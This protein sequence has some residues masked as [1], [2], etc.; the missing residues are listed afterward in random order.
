M[1]RSKKRRRTAGGAR[2][3]TVSQPEEATTVEQ[4]LV[5]AGNAR[6][7]SVQPEP[8]TDDSQQTSTMG[9]TI[10][11]PIASVNDNLGLHV[12][13]NVKQKIINGE[14]IELA[15]LLSNSMGVSENTHKISLIDGE[16][17]VKPKTQTPKILDIS[18]WT[19]AFIIYISIYTSVHSEQLHGLLKYMQIVRLGAQRCG[20]TDWLKYDEQYRLRKS[21]KPHEPWGIVD[22]ELYLIY[23]QPQKQALP[24]TQNQNSPKCFDFNY[25]GSCAR[26]HCTYSH[27]CMRCNRGH[28]SLNCFKTN[29]SNANSFRSK[30]NS[31]TQSNPKQNKQGGYRQGTQTGMD[32]GKNPNKNS[33]S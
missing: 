29:V 21:H 7:E 30:P 28:A 2:Q 17:V 3:P 31:Y 16:L 14:Y 33:S 10:P 9:M 22:N 20:G 18:K 6:P 15:L 24:Q 13:T 8:N 23:M 25:K 27:K 26:S 12:A 11:T 5:S 4:P 1:Y 32:T 19:Y